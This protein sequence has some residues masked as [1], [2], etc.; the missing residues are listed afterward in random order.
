MLLRNYFEFRGALDHTVEVYCMLCQR[1]IFEMHEDSVNDGL[2]IAECH[3][4]ECHGAGTRQSNEKSRGGDEE[5]ADAE[6]IQTTEKTSVSPTERAVPV[7]H[8]R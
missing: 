8:E 3:W 7:T 5:A 4:K 1:I 6:P 2:E